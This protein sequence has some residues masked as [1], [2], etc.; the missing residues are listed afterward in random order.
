[1]GEKTDQGIFQRIKVIQVSSFLE[2][3]FQTCYDVCLKFFKKL[4]NVLLDFRILKNLLKDLLHLY[5]NFQGS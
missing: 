1:M 3:F 4:T 2:I 5:V